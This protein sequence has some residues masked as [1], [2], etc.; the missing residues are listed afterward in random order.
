[1]LKEGKWI[2]KKVLFFKVFLKFQKIS[3]RVTKQTSL[4]ILVKFQKT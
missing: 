1:M 4:N 3:M 2:Y